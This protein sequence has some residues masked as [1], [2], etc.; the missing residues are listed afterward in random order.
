L[1]RKAKVGCSSRSRSER[2]TELFAAVE[3]VVQAVKRDSL[4]FK[5]TGLGHMPISTIPGHGLAATVVQPGPEVLTLQSALIDAVAPFTADRGDA[6][7]FVTTEDEPHINAD[8]LDYVANYVPVHSGAN[9]IAHMTAGLAP[10]DFLEKIERQPF[11]AFD[12][13]P[14]GFAIYQLGNNG[15]AR[16]KLRTLSVHMG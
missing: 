9:F 14:A 10:L 5:A 6:R 7:A 1:V 13:H 11:D 4:S 16:K 15:T 8:T 3:E 2:L 12:F